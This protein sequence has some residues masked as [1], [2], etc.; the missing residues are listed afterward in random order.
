MKVKQ[1][2]P[3]S[4]TDFPGFVACVAHLGSVINLKDYWNEHKIIRYLME[5]KQLVDGIVLTG[6]EPTL[7]MSVYNFCKRVK[8]LGFKIKLDTCGT[9]PGILKRL[10]DE[11]LVDYIS[12]E[13]KAPPEKYLS[14]T[15]TEFSKVKEA[16]RLV[17]GFEHHEFK[18]YVSDALDLN[19]IQK[20]SA[21]TDKENYFLSGKGD[22]IRWSHDLGIRARI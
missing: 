21:L 18:T 17:R 15:G 12:M 2:V 4:Y 16:Y 6:D 10:I 19:D 8:P 3:C 22:I 9:G 1:F 5:N 20:I 13:L 14:L 11:G 7:D